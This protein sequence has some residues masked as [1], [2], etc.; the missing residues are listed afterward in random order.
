M[1]RSIAVAVE[2]S[3]NGKAFMKSCAR[4]LLPRE[5]VKRD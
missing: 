1:L 2:T 3:V 5:K 4:V